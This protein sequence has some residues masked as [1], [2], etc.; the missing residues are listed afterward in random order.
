[1][2]RG[3][4]VIHHWYKSCDSKCLANMA[5]NIT[6]SPGNKHIV[7]HRDKTFAQVTGQGKL[8]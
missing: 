5:A 7:G 1:M 4:V 2:T 8:R 6:G 3:Q